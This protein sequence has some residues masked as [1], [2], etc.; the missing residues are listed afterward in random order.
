MNTSRSKAGLSA[1][2]IADWT[3]RLENA[4]ENG[5]VTRPFRGQKKG[6]VS[7][8][9]KVEELE[10]GLVRKHFR[11]AQNAIG[12]QASFDAL[13]RVMTKRPMLKARHFL[14]VQLIIF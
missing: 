4:Y 3:K 8:V 2:N 12:N 11:Y 13:A 10:R 14:I 7:V 9:D 6:R 1:R 5:S